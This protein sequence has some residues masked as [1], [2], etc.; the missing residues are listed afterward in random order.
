M[1]MS[2]KSLFTSSRTSISSSLKTISQIEMAKTNANCVPLIPDNHKWS[3]HD[4]YHKLVLSSTTP[5][6]FKQL[7]HLTKPRT[8]NDHISME[9]ERKLKAFKR[10]FN[11]VGEDP[12][13]SLVIID[14]V[15]RLGIDHHFQEE[16][17]TI[18]Q[19]LYYN[20]A[21]IS[22]GSGGPGGGYFSH[23]HEVS[24]RFRL[25]RQQGYYVSPEVF[26][27]FKDNTGKFKE[28]LGEDISGLMA[29]YEASHL[30]LEGESVL[31]EAADYSAQLLHTCVTNLAHNQATMVEHTLS[32]P[33]HKSFSKFT[34]KKY[35]SHGFQDTNNG[36]INIL[37]GL[38][39]IDFD[40]A[41][42]TYQ[43]EIV[44]ISKWWKKLG[45]AKEM[46][47]AR[48]QPLKWYIW[49]MACI[50]DPSLSEERIDL[51]KS[52]SFIYLIDDIFDLYGT[53][54][55]LT[56]FT[57]VVNRWDYDASEQLPHYM[58]ICFQAL[59][60]IINE[61]SFKMYKKHGWNPVESLRKSWGRLCSAFLVE[62]K[63]FAS[64]YVPASEEYLKNGI[65]S[66]G[67][68]VV[69][70]QLFF[71]LGC[72][73][74]ITKE[75]VESI[76]N[77]PA[78]V[79]STAQILRLWDDLGSAKDEDQDGHDGSYLEYYMKEHQGCS[80][81][82]AEEHVMS[83]ISDAWK[84]LNKECM[85][86]TPFS[87]SFIKATLNLAR[88]VPLMYSYDNNQRLPSLE[89]NVKSILSIAL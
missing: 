36:W 75:S 57:Q 80:V 76:D 84:Q 58:K 20:E 35:L 27:C 61:I 66:S 11:I 68:H 72:Q 16:I 23:L 9:H 70:V 67:V 13:E 28:N 8:P 65:I 12:I 33:H 46:S 21:N 79:S 53:Q 52:I 74:I 64:G 54:D 45:L 39:K 50:T 60:G 42:S 15:Q 10:I 37:K 17:N 82:E 4:V 41:Q 56:L 25:L 22:H 55:E 87:Q 30:C 86:P 7:N 18:L 3:T 78:I 77:D 32:H 6:P 31:Q 71:L 26:D 89:D 44:Q 62:G 29:L 47:L 73:D 38:A 24:L 2:S 43:K 1:A 59:D 5:P 51:T 14:A 69:C 85:T 83:K 81:K 48:D 34:G 88:M 49:S 40:M 19:D 63:W